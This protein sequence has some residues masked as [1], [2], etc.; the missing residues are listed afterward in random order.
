MGGSE[1]ASGSSRL[2][3]ACPTSNIATRAD[4]SMWVVRRWY[5]GGEELCGDEVVAQ[6][7]E[8]GLNIV[9]DPT[10]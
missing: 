4:R 3:L 9:G 5:G 8:G 10:W 6:S 1:R 7:A 2:D